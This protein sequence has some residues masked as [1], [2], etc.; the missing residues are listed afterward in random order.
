MYA[1]VENETIII[2]P[3]TMEMIRK[4]FPNI[5]F[6]NTPTESDLVGLPVVL[7]QEAPQPEHSPETHN[8]IEVTPV[9]EGNIWSQK[10]ELVE[11]SENEINERQ[12]QMIERFSFM[13]QL[14]MDTIAK[15]KGYGDS[16]TSPSVSARSYAGFPNPFQA[17]CIL[18]SQWAASCWELCY[19]ILDEVKQ[20]TR[21]IPTEQE[22]IDLLP[23][24]S[25]D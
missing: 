23:P 5:S 13:V 1:K 4:D 2:S 21:P 20:E 11:L 16:R 8:C 12:N 15:Q 14:H 10:W 18:F 24:F 7:V 25:W 22:L 3:Y 6:P 17:E 19:Q 9:F